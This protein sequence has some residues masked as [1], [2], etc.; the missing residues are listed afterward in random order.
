MKKRDCINALNCAHAAASIA[1]T[2]ETLL[3]S[4]D[5]AAR[6]TAARLLALS[7]ALI[8]AATHEL[9]SAKAAEAR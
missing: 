4:A 8:E 2:A 9:Q 3:S 6:D 5:G 7:N 1:T